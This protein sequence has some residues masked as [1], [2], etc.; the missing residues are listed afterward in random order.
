MLKICVIC[1]RKNDPKKE[2]L[3]I[4]DFSDE[5]DLSEESDIETDE[6]C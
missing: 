2:F 3:E 4:T 5:I 6:T 1:G